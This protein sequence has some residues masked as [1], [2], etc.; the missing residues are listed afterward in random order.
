[1][2]GRIKLRSHIVKT[3]VKTTVSL[4]FII[5]N[6]QTAILPF[7]MTSNNINIGSIETTKYMEVI[8]GIVSKNE[9]LAPKN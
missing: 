6:S 2:A 7:T 8:K 4:M 1:M 5:D 9:M 3:V